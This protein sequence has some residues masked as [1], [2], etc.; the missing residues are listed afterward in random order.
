MTA[1]KCILSALVAALVLATAAATAPADLKSDAAATDRVNLRSAEDFVILAKTG[2][3][4][5]PASDITGDIGVSPIAATAL[6]GFSL[7]A[8]SSNK[9]ST[10]TQI[11]GKAYAADYTAP[12]PATMTTAMGD[13]ETAYTDA[14]A[15]PV[16][17]GKSDFKAGLI[18]GETLTAGVYHWGS[19]VMFGSDITIKGCR[20]DIFIFQTTGNVVVGS[21]A[22]VTLEKGGIGLCGAPK[23]SNIFWQVAGFVDAGKAS[24]LEGVFLV[25][26]NAAFQTDASLNGRILAQTAC[27]LGEATIT[28]P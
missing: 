14:A 11:T 27:T 25:Q 18:S 16:D 6:T 12:T 19:D 8:D 20:S 24:H 17:H 15:R 9:F 28:Q 7:V 21:D 26:T 5:V 10:S 2:I 23:A 3:S 22:K 4:T 13:M 1:F